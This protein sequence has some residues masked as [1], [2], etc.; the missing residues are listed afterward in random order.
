MYFHEGSNIKEVSAPE[1]TET[2]DSIP[3]TFFSRIGTPEKE[4]TIVHTGDGK[5]KDLKK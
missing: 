1:Q 3:V 4:P 2:S 5:S